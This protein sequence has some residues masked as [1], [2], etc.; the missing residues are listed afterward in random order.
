[1]KNDKAIN[2]LNSRINVLK[3]EIELSEILLIHTKLDPELMFIRSDVD[4]FNLEINQ[5][6]NTIQFLLK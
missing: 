1:M 2:C 3:N 5:L 6:T 4:N